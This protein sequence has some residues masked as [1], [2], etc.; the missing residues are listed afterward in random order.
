[1]QHPVGDI[2]NRLVARHRGRQYLLRDHRAVDVEIGSRHVEDVDLTGLVGFAEKPDHKRNVAGDAQRQAPRDRVPMI[3]KEHDREDHLEE[4]H[5]RHND[6][7]RS[8]QQ[9]FG[10]EALDHGVADLVRAQDIA[11]APNGL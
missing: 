4:H 5:R 11:L 6:R 8:S 3:V 2:E 10:Q 9:C 7:D 1:M